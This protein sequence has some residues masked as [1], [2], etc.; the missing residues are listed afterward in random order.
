MNDA[1]NL[2]IERTSSPSAA[3]V[4]APTSDDE[5]VEGF[6]ARFASASF[7]KIGFQ[8]MPVS[9]EVAKAADGLLK[10]M[11]QNK[12]RALLQA[13]RLREWYRRSVVCHYT[14]RPVEKC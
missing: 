6:R 14:H 13:E 12:V 2:L 10:Y 5:L 9:A 7:A 3:P 1:I 8:Q 11:P 4:V